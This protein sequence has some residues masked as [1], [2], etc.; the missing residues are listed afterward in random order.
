MEAWKIKNFYSDNETSKMI[1]KM[2]K[3]SDNGYVYFN[4]MLN[5]CMKLKYGNMKLNK[6][7]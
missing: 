3:K 1:I 7:M 4:Q 2:G 6:Q 5:N